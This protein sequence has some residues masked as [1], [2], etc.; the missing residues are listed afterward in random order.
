[1]LSSVSLP[2]SIHPKHSAVAVCQKHKM[3]HFL[4]S[5]RTQKRHIRHQMFRRANVKASINWLTFETPLYRLAMKITRMKIHLYGNAIDYYFEELLWVHR[6]VMIQAII[7]YLLA[8]CCNFSHMALSYDEIMMQAPLQ[9][10]MI[11]CPNTSLAR[12]LIQAPC[13]NMPLD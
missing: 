5:Q 1:M 3:H 4:W 8:M 10:E 13:K 6:C 9:S 2:S 11:F 7:F 12:L